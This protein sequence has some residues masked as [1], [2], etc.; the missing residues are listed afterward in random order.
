MVLIPIPQEV[1]GLAGHIV[2]LLSVAPLRAGNGHA[3]DIRAIALRQDLRGRPI[4]A[5]NVTNVAAF[6]CA[7]EFGHECHQ[8]LRCLGVALLAR[9]PETVVYMLAPDLAVKL[10]EVIIVRS[11]TVDG[12]FVVAESGRGGHGCLVDV[13][14]NASRPILPSP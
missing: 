7:A 8:I 3:G 5:A 4:A 13:T 10:I 9:E 12:G 1:S 11:S 2:V 14:L 6:A